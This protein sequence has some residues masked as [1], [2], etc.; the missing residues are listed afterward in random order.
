MKGIKKGQ[1]ECSRLLEIQ[2]SL[3]QA[4]LIRARAVDERGVC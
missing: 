3:L 1:E 2:I 4:P